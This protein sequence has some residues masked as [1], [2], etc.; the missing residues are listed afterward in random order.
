MEPSDLKRRRVK[1]GYSQDKF[2]RRI[3]VATGTIS[4]WEQ[5]RSPIPEW[6]SVMLDL[7]ERVE[8]PEKTR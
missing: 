5:G 7:L 6:L 4:S 1:L 3:G 8:R 2:A